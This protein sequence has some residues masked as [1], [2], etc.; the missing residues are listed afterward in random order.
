MDLVLLKVAIKDK[1]EDV[2]KYKSEF[3]IQTPIMIDDGQVANAY[4]VWSHPETFFI[5]RDGKIVGR[6]LKEMD[7]TSKSM[8][9]LVQFLLRRKK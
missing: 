4:G 2:R 3:K 1:E 7:W 5:N 8:K 6:V 9:N